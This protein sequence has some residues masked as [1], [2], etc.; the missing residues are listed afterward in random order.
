MNAAHNI[1][2]ALRNFKRYRNTLLINVI[3]ITAGMVCLLVSF[4]W[5]NDELKM[6]RFHAKNDQ[7]YEVMKNVQF[8]GRTDTDNYTPYRLAAALKSEMP[9]VSLAASFYDFSGQDYPNGIL[10]YDDKLLTVKPAAIGGDF[11]KVFSYKMVT[12]N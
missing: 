6:D 9:E 11:F 1:L 8:E 4:L 12:G 2:M 7:L 10:S 5:I 3:G